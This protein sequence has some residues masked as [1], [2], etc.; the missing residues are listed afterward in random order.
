MSSHLELTPAT[1]FLP[2]ISKVKVLS[3]LLKVRY[4]NFRTITKQKT[5]TTQVIAVVF[6]FH[7]VIDMGKGALEMVT[8][9]CYF[10]EL[11]DAEM[12]YYCLL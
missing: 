5:T 4:S 9:E 11:V 6:I 7:S 3:V 10:I 8:V 2:F 1:Y 12:V